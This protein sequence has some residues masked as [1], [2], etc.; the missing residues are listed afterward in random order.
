M[1]YYLSQVWLKESEDVTW[2]RIIEALLSI[3][4]EDL[5]KTTREKFCSPTETE[6]VSK[7]ADQ[8]IKDKVILI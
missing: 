6:E 2:E 5:A 8:S 3:G 7:P 4:L 1:L